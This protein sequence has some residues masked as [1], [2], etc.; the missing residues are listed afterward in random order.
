MMI[1]SRITISLITDLLPDS[2]NQSG[3]PMSRRQGPTV[4]GG[5]DSR[6]KGSKCRFKHLGYGGYFQDRS[7]YVESFIN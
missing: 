6:G 2:G 5:F 1:I 7:S 4:S 3:N